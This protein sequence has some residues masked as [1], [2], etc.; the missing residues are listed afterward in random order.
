MKSCLQAKDYSDFMIIQ[1]NKFISWRVVLTL[2]FCLAAQS[3]EALAERLIVK[4]A[5]QEIELDVEVADDSAERS[6]GLMHV[7]YLPLDAGMLFDFGETR[8]ITMWM[9]NTKIPLDMFFVD[10]GGKIL[11]IKEEAEPYSLDI[12]SSGSTARAVLEVNGGF[13]HENSIQVGDKLLHPLFENK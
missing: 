5:E 4:T 8:I 12:I 3:G 6:R 1:F 11:Y 13:A 9:R 10:A 7:D 2:I